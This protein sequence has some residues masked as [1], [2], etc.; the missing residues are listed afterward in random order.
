[1]F[2]VLIVLFFFLAGLVDWLGF[3]WA[4]VAVYF[5]VLFPAASLLGR[6]IKQRCLCH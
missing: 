6:L 2:W 3:R 4:A 1:M 5:V